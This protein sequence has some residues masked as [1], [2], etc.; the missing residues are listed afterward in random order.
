MIQLPWARRPGSLF[1]DLRPVA[2]Q[3][4]ICDLTISFDKEL[5]SKWGPNQMFVR[6]CLIP[7]EIARPFESYSL[8]LIDLG[9][10]EL[11]VTADAIVERSGCVRV[12]GKPLILKS[13]EGGE[14]QAVSLRSDDRV[15][16]SV[17]AQLLFPVLG[18]VPESRLPATRANF[19]AGCYEYDSRLEQRLNEKLSVSDLPELEETFL[20]NK[21]FRVSLWPLTRFANNYLQRPGQ[22]AEMVKKLLILLVGG[23]FMLNHDQSCGAEQQNELAREVILLS[24]EFAK[25]PLAAVRKTLELQ[26]PILV[27][28]LNQ[29]QLAIFQAHLGAES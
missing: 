18:P 22:S 11:R 19:F 7:A 24:L 6:L 3:V 10:Q 4:N 23:I 14:G 25:H 13:K 20:G 15:S 27:G 1:K 29:E 5:R 2:A 28:A 26:I 9:G 12:G 16:I 17:P 8:E 21:I